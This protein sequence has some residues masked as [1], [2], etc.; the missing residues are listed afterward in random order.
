MNVI[1]YDDP[2]IRIQ[3]LP[4]TFTR[5][6][7]L[8][9]VGI[10]TIAEKWEGFLKV[11]ASFA[12][13]TYL[14]TKY[15]S[16]FT[17][18]NLWINGA[19]CPDAA[20]VNVIQSLKPGDAVRKGSRILAVR[21]PDDEVPEVITGTVHEYD[22]DI[23][24]IDQLWKIFQCNGQQI[25][26]DF[27]RI[28]KGR[29]SKTINDKHTVIYH[30][31]NVFVEE[32]V[33]TKA[34][35]L[36]AESGPIYLG[37]NSQVQEGA[38]IRGPFAIGEESV[39]NMGGKMRGDTTI[40]PFCKVGGEISNAVVFG[41]SNKGHDGFLGNSVLGEWCNLG[42]DTNVSNLKNN[43]DKVKL[44]SYATNSFI[45]TDAQFCGLIMGDHSKCGINT[46][47]N[48][49]TVVGV[50]AN[51]FG[52]GYPRNFVPSYSWGGAAGFSTYQFDKA[53]ET[54]E[55]VLGRRNL[56]LSDVD[57]SILK[58]VFELTATYRVW[59]KK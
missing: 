15:A 50:S 34:A 55:R 21:T 22:G 8:I 51:V 47:F 40:G 29:T 17:E 36:N 3:L 9:R 39:I 10:Q 45:K 46:M 57:R 52:D 26:S 58:S 12:T 28:T 44:W 32:G 13:P 48:T 33:I 2:S 18:D 14:A 5:P 1:L 59:D 31:E 27:E 38:V 16:K 56:A 35:I 53:T 23:V 24:L 25:R 11:T 37:K 6:V 49:G 43:Y 30:P 4:L 20:L 7:A 54:A 41:Y 19:L 42:A